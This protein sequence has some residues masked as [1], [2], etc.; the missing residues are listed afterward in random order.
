MGR[1]TRRDT[2]LYINDADSSSIPQRDRITEVAGTRRSTNTP[3]PI[4]NKLHKKPRSIGK[5]NV[6][7]DRFRTSPFAKAVHPRILGTHHGDPW[8]EYYTKVLQW[9][10]L[11]GDVYLAVRRAAPESYVNIR[12]FNGK[13]AE[14][15]LFWIQQIR[16]DSFVK[17][18]EAFATDSVLYV[19]LEEMNITLSHV[20][21]CSRY[22]TPLEVGAI[23]G[24]VRSMI[25]R[26]YLC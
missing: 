13:E 23:L 14:D 22:P 12:E 20:I 8:K 2:Q 24:Q 26:P 3:T 19:V 4:K 15:A 7:S 9:H 16:H 17:A 1:Y 11:G 5:G 21:S 18:L 10:D 25:L 6:E